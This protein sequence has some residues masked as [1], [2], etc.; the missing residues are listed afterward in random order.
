VLEHVRRSLRL[1]IPVM[2]GRAGLIIMI[3]V[4]SIMTGRAAAEELAYYAISLA[5]HMTLL[6]VGIG[7]MI[8]T[9]VLT[10]QSDGAGRRTE[11]AS[12]WVTSLG[13]AGGLGAV[14]CVVLLA[15]EHLLLWLGQSPPIAAGGAGPLVMFAW[16]MP[17]ILMYIAT[18]F[19][20]EGLSRPGPGMVVALS[21]NLVNAGLNWVFI[22]GHL[23]APE[24]G[25]AGAALATSIT[26]YV[27][28][29]ALAWY[30]VR[31]LGHGRH[32]FHG[33]LRIRREIARRLLAIGAP[34]SIA[35]GLETACFATVTAF[36]GHLGAVPLAGFQIPFNVITFVF[37]LAIGLS[38]STSVRVA[39]A[40]GRRDRPGMA[41]A[42]WTGLGLVVVLMFGLAAAISAF[43]PDI[44]GLYTADAAVLAIAA[45]AMSL[46]ALITIV[47]GAQA[48]ALGALRGAGDVLIPTLSHAFSFWVV[49]VPTAY[50]LGVAG[51]T[52][53]RG[54]L[55]G[56]FAGLTCAVVLLSWRFA[57]VSRRGVHPV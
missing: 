29:A 8:G 2:L 45:P 34:L 54:L 19:F 20:L 50:V 39:N 37:M 43:G 49:A 18:T 28:L 56:L 22:Y 36:A 17:A 38:T 42:G 40:V 3:T 33:P 27:M 24:M 35:A 31:M 12:I 51:S 53:V 44:A 21:A 14:W 1:A 48:V 41:A 47:D 4:D 6:V 32:G 11:A 15:G 16:G 23:G 9:V 25:A 46:A 52:G 55:W 26:R 57:V 30:A 10:A 5:P 7:L 13:I